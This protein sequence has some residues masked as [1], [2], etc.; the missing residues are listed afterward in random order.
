MSLNSVV[1]LSPNF[2]HVGC[3]SLFRG[4]EGRH[5]FHGRNVLVSSV[6]QNTSPESKGGG[7]VLVHIFV[8]FVHRW[9]CV[10]GLSV[11]VA[12]PE[13]LKEI[14]HLSREEYGERP[15]RAVSKD[16]SPPHTHTC[17]HT[18]RP[19]TSSSHI[20]PPP[21]FTT[22]SNAPVPGRHSQT[23]WYA[24]LIQ[25]SLGTVK[26]VIK[27]AYGTGTVADSFRKD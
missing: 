14:S 18:S 22:T 6:W 3:K 11:T 2:T 25:E 10:L 17:T 8:E 19:E 27:A 9:P 1:S 5:V 12:G 24:S 23:H 13:L 20:G 16:M 4:S 7:L 15:G 21:V 26:P